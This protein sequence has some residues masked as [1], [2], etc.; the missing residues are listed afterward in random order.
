MR[1]L[2]GQVALKQRRD[3]EYGEEADAPPPRQPSVAASAG[4]RAQA[5]GRAG[6]R[7]ALL[8]WAGAAGGAVQ[9]VAASGS[10]LPGAEGRSPI[11]VIQLGCVSARRPGGIPAVPAV[12]LA[13]SSR[14][15][16]QGGEPHAGSCPRAVS[17][18]GVTS[19]S[20]ARIANCLSGLCFQVTPCRGRLA[21]SLLA[22]QGGG[23]CRLPPPA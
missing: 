12:P 6:R 17:W 21:A 14:A 7:L 13:A 3:H 11:R 10:V 5:C 15:A 1:V 20:R 9:R 18:G 23:G 2:S 22:H 16:R 19:G 4:R 8:D